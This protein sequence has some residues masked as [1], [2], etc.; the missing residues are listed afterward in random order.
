MK[1]TF[2]LLKI[3][4]YSTG[5]IRCFT[6]YSSHRQ[7][8]PCQWFIKCQADRGYFPLMPNFIVLLVMIHTFRLKFLL[9]T[10]AKNNFFY[11][12]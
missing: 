10:G 11:L 3:L 1:Q 2:A 5:D 4:Q 6:I 12:L 7:Q 8:S 9:S